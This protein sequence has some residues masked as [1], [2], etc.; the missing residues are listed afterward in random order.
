MKRQ[1]GRG[2]AVVG[3]GKSRFGMF[4]DRDS[5]DLFAEAFTRMLACVDKGIDPND[6]EALYLG[7]F[8]NA[9]QRHSRRRATT[10]LRSD[11]P[12]PSSPVEQDL[13]FL[14]LIGMIDP[15]RDE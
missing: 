2:V 9:G 8:S 6:I 10:R 12:A 14:G 15:P 13:V 5:K 11:H 3:V 7:N 1:L 4:A